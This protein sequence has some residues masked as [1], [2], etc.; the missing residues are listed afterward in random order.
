MKMADLKL[1]DL[2]KHFGST[3]AVD[4][5]NLTVASGELVA[6]LGPSG[7]GKT[8]TLR[9]IAG[10]VE[11]TSG[12]VLVQGQEITNLPPNRRD[13]GMVFQ[14]YALF[15]HMTVNQ[16][17][18]FGLHARRVPRAAV[19][20]RISDSLNLV[21]L[22]NLGDR[23]PRQLSG[24]QQQR[25]AL[26][27]ILALRPKL[28]L[29]D[30]P[31]SNLDA[32][33]RV[34]M[35]HEIRRLQKEVGI[36]ALFVTHDQEEAMTI[37]DRIVVMNEGR[38]EQE[39]PPADVY[40]FP[41]T[42]F[43]ADFIGTAN[44]FAGQVRAGEFHSESGLVFPLPPPPSPDGRASLAIRPEN[45]SLSTLPASGGLTGLVSRATRLGSIT[46]YELV[47]PSREKIIVQ[48]HGRALARHHEPG[49]SLQ[50]QWRPEDLRIIS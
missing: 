48:E 33:L 50:L 49:T 29:F 10:F 31:L 22:T 11:P 28:L 47:L 42:R 20:S 13:M 14:S 9:M 19:Q 37:A 5:I 21:G 26:A 35:R 12:N 16:N 44:M 8:T 4:R 43:V 41:K 7:C 2:T 38:I 6:F 24:G 17:V 34:Q 1:K 3:V 25:V 40:D 18:A 15:P 39:G 23:Y 30:E 46:E 32:K 45:I 27:R 36:T